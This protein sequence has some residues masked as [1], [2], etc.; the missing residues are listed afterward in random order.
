MRPILAPFVA[1]VLLVAV[2][3]FAQ[4]P[5]SVDDLIKQAERAGIPEIAADATILD[6]DGK[7]LRKGTNGW[8][9]IAHPEAPMCGDEQ[10]AS[11]LDAYGNK[12]DEVDVTAVGIS[13]MLQGDQGVSNVDPFAQ[14]PTPDNEWV[15][16]GP[17]LMIIVPDPDLLAGIPTDPSG[18]G[19][20][21]MW[22][23]TPFVHVMIPVDGGAVHMPHPPGGS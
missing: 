22:R 4:H 17:H 9:C 23:D 16:T 12:R 21:V 20:Y 14:K 10:W 3:A 8:T 18:G 15:V 1:V 2:P 7:V 13:Y 5:A 19:P 11:W 6:A